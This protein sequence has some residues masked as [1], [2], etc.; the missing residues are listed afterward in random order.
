MLFRLL[1]LL[2]IAVLLMGFCHPQTSLVLGDGALVAG[3]AFG[4]GKK[5]GL[6]LWKSAIEV[7]KGNSDELSLHDMRF[8]QGLER[9]VTGLLK[10]V[11]ISQT[12]NLVRRSV[13][14]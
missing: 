14:S 6:V 9:D 4:V 12:A 10:S 7:T 1:R 8:T 13:K 5:D 3:E 2:L 11:A